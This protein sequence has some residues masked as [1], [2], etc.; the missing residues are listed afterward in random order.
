[1][2]AASLQM[3]FS[4]VF[5]YAVAGLCASGYRLATDKLPSFSV[6]STGARPETVAMVPLLI[7][8]APFLIMR[9]T[10][11]GRRQEARRFEFVFLA[12]LIAGFWSLMSG[13]GVIMTLQACGLA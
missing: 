8:S 4:L 12:T 1:M 5:G 6:L 11:V 3:L 7:L 2:S 13:I 10:L 9:N